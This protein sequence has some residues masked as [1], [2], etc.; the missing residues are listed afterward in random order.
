MADCAQ[1]YAK[2]LTPMWRN[3]WRQDGYVFAKRGLF[4]AYAGIEE[5][6]RAKKIGI[7]RGTPMR[8]DEFRSHQ[9]GNGAQKSS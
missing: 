9:W 8:P 5:Q 3:G 2:L 6:A 1:G 7:W 4:S